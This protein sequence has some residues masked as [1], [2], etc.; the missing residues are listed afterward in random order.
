MLRRFLRTKS[1]SDGNM[2]GIFVTQRKTNFRPMALITIAPTALH[3][4]LGA[5]RTM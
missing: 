4:E 5:Q 3:I 1:N 2:I